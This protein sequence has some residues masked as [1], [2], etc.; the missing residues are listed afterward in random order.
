MLAASFIVQV[1]VVVPIGNVAGALL[2]TV[3]GLRVQ[4]SETFG[5]PKLTLLAVHL[6]FIARV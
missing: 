6:S 1:T 5:A 4:L 2:V 3:T